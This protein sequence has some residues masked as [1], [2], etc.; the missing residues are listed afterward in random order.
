MQPTPQEVLIGIE[1]VKA[2]MDWKSDSTVYEYIKRGFPKP[3]KSSR[4]C[5]RWLV[6]EVTAWISDRVRER[7]DKA[8]A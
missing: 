5:A 8:A 7:D 3:I 4:R 6:S 1:S 2:M